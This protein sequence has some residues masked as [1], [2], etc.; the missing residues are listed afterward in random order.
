MAFIIFN[1]NDNSGVY[2]TA[3]T[4]T[5]IDQNKGWN[6]SHVDVID[7]SDDVFN[8][9][10]YGTS[11]F[12]SRSGNTINWDTG[13]SVKYHYKNNLEK[14][15]KELIDDIDEWL[16]NK[17]NSNKPMRAS[18]ITFKEYLEGIDVSSIITDPS[19]SATYDES[20]DSWS[21]GTPLTKSLIKYCVDQGQTAYHYTELL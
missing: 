16:N 3:A 2:R 9:F 15:I 14:E 5:I 21:D 13:H 10:R 17:G 7:V 18:V 19:D 12:S 11:F 1:K 8:N 4:Q 20:T 6:D